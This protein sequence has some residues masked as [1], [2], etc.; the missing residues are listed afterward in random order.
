MPP[1]LRLTLCLLAVAIAVPAQ[2]QKK[3]GE[4]RPRIGLALAGGSA[5]GLTHVGALKWL[6]EHRIPV[7]FVAGTSMGGLVGGLY[8]TGRSAVEVEDFIREVNWAVAFQS[9]ASFRD[10]SFR[11]KEDQREYPNPIELGLRDGF[12]FPSGLNSGHGVSL[13]ISRFA[14][15][16]GELKSFDDLPTPFRCVATDLVKSKEVVFDSGSLP[17]ALRATMSLPAI[18][19]PIRKDDMLLV[20]GGMINNLPTDVVRS[21]G[22]EIVIAVALDI[23]QPKAEEVTGLFGVA[24][25]SLSVIVIQN[26][27]RNLG[28]ADLVV[29]PDLEGVSGSDFNKWQDLIERGYK[30]AEAKRRMLEPFALSETEYAE[31]RKAREA[32]RR[33]STVR[34]QVVEVASQLAPRRRD[35]LIDAVAA[36]PAQPVDQSRLEA[37]LNKVVGMGRYDSASYTFFDR[38]GQEGVRLNV[39]E[40]EHGP[41]FLK[42]AITLDANR[43]EGIQFGIGAR[44]T[45]LDFG[46]PASEWRTDFSI[47]VLNKIATEYYYRIRGGKWFV[48]PRIGYEEQEYPIYNGSDR[49]AEYTTRF[50]GGGA[51]LGYAFGRFNEFRVGWS[52]HNY[53][54]DQTQG[55][56][57]GLGYEGALER[58]RLR[59]AHE[60]QDSAIIP[61]RGV[62]AVV[63]GSWVTQHPEVDRQFAMGE[64]Q[65]SWAKT[66]PRHLLLITRAGGGAAPNEQP[67]F[68]AFRLGGPLNMSSL[69]RSQ[70]LGNHYYFGG[71]S[72]LRPF[73]PQQIS[74]FGRFYAALSYEAGNAWFGQGWFA[75]RHSGSLGLMGET[76][77]G[78]VFFGGA[79][80]DQGDRRLFFRLGRFF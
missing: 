8:A 42:P 27:R 3:G 14:A 24:R 62:R 66:L 39:H 77:L 78:V 36:D 20:D 49:I 12:Q 48:A 58:F 63:E 29:M 16:Y 55:V 25:R 54:N 71:A 67:L 73:T 9:G 1:L 28:Q 41:P 64:A 80:G 70:L 45:F 56:A 51:D 6:E 10:S 2:S 74:A 75:P 17:E 72:V 38:N 5:L 46:G 59:W 23:P 61:S 19:A 15:S 79:I 43:G 65:A 76:P 57:Q 21:M 52:L 11:R 31:W 68:N 13:I 34:P 26:E 47:G 30:A 44:L 53:T 37:E 35:A 32:K 60:G 40:K 4:P 7:D 69:A 50:A 18:F 22:A 33:P